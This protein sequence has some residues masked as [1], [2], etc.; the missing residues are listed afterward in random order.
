[1]TDFDTA[2]IIPEQVKT[3]IGR[4][5]VVIA[6]E[7]D[8]AKKLDYL[9]ALLGEVGS[10]LKILMRYWKIE[11]NDKLIW[12]VM[13]AMVISEIKQDDENGTNYKQALQIIQ[14]LKAKY[15]LSLST[16]KNG[17]KITKESVAAGLI[18]MR[19]WYELIG[20][21]HRWK[22]ANKIYFSN[23]EAWGTSKDMASDIFFVL[24]DIANK[25]NMIIIPKNTFFSIDEIN[26]YG[27]SK[28]IDGD[29]N[30]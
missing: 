13:R 11:T 9:S 28:V 22:I 12:D 25:N 26:N 20:C 21:R 29:K 14:K 3:T 24:V 10:A 4:L 1:M 6:S 23:Q 16:D 18:L 5:I 19:D 15:D 8:A 27:T 30:G 2:D 7:G 17:H